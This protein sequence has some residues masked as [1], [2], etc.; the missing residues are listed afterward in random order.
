MPWPWGSTCRDHP[1]RGRSPAGHSIRPCR[2]SCPTSWSRRSGSA[3]AGSAPLRKPCWSWPPSWA[4][5]WRSRTWP[6]PRA[7]TPSH[8]RQPSTSSN[9]SAGSPPSPAGTASLRAS[10]ARSWPATWSWRGNGSA[11]STRRDYDPQRSLADARGRSRDTAAQGEHRGVTTAGDGHGVG[12]VAQWSTD[13][14]PQARRDAVVDDRRNG[15]ERGG[16][17]RIGREGRRSR[18]EQAGSQEVH[19][20]ELLGELP[21]DRLVIQRT[22]DQYLEG[23]PPDRHSAYV[24]EP[25]MKAS[26]VVGAALQH[27]RATDPAARGGVGDLGL[28]L[29]LVVPGAAEGEHSGGPERCSFAVERQQRGPQGAGMGVAGPDEVHRVRLLAE[30]EAGEW[31]Q[32][33]CPTR[34]WQRDE[35]ARSRRARARGAGTSEA[36]PGGRCRMTRARAER[37]RCQDSDNC[38]AVHRGLMARE[39]V[40]PLSEVARYR[41]RL[42]RR[43]SPPRSLSA[44]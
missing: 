30:A 35:R 38:G 39:Q 6:A 43:S 22:G 29:R 25:Q 20:H 13:R 17:D 21:A 37:E 28:H 10:C 2:A 23:R 42:K 41:A 14:L 36:R 18:I 16:I 5:G 27:D 44:A 9:G 33:E 32:F 12:H 15:A 3:F 40:R 1:P 11:S 34:Q 26:L 4:A 7:S 24:E 31:P 8:W 19:H